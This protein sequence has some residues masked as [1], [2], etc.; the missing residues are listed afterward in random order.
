MQ[1]LHVREPV[2]DLVLLLLCEPARADGAVRG[3]ERPVWHLPLPQCPWLGGDGVWGLRRMGVAELGRDLTKY[4]ISL[5]GGLAL[6]EPLQAGGQ[7]RRFGACGS[8]PAVLACLALPFL[9][10]PWLACLLGAEDS[11]GPLVDQQHRDGV[12]GH[13]VHHRPGQRRGQGP[14]RWAWLVVT[15]VALRVGLAVGGEKLAVQLRPAPEGEE[16]VA[17]LALLD[18]EG[19]VVAAWQGHSGPEV[20]QLP[21]N[22]RRQVQNVDV[23]EQHAVIPLMAVP[24]KDQH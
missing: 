16:E 14:I 13:M 20:R 18:N 22:P 10:P 11:G 19:G 21:P 7:L 9:L 12:R 15:D 3:L 6:C 17:T 24:P 23:V 8:L 5:T 1:L 2:V 4:P